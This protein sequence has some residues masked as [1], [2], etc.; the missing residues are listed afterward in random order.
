MAF[1][2]NIWLVS[3]RSFNFLAVQPG[4]SPA[5]CR[6]YPSKLTDCNRCCFDSQYFVGYCHLSVDT[7]YFFPHGQALS[8]FAR[9]RKKEA[10][11]FEWY[12][13]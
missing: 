8:V 11:F 1:I 9:A 4:F 12:T 7:V 10:G 5:V 2:Y 6:D 3:S 13:S